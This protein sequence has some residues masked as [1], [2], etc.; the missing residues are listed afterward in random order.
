MARG[1]LRWRW[2]IEQNVFALD[3]AHV[4]VTRAAAYVLVYPFQREH[5]SV[6]VDQR[7]LPLGRHMA[8]GTPADCTGVCKLQ[9][10]HFFVTRLALPGS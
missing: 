2:L 4:L 8:L 10:V 7:W 6:V 3:A 5:G 9:S 1:A